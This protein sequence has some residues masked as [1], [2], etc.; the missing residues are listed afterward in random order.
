MLS[1]KT[2]YGS[3]TPG[4]YTATVGYS[5]TEQRLIT[6]VKDR[7]RSISAL[8]GQTEMFSLEE[9][10]RGAVFGVIGGVLTVLFVK[11]L[12]KMDQGLKRESR[13]NN[14]NYDFIESQK[15]PVIHD[16]RDC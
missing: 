14:D 4:G 1:K 13:G 7:V 16:E 9:F 15:Q 3:P 5:A 8:S 11:L 6:T 10:C 12:E 2:S